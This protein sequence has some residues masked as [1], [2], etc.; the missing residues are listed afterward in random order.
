M[1]TAAVEVASKTA[2]KVVIHP[3][4]SPFAE[5]LRRSR[6]A[7]YDPAIRQTYRTPSANA[8]RGDWGLKRPISLRRRNAFI[9]I[10]GPFEAHAQFIEWNNA[11]GEVR[12]IRQLEEMDIKPRV[13]YDTPWHKSVGIAKYKLLLD[14]EFCPE[15]S[16]EQDREAEEDRKKKNMTLDLPGLGNRG[17]GM[18]SAKRGPPNMGPADSPGQVTENIDAMSTKEFARYLGK[19]RKLRPKFAEFLR[20]QEHLRGK[21]LYAIAQ[22][23]EGI[24]HRRF[25]QEHFK[26]EFSGGSRQVK[27]EQQPHPNAGLMYAQPTVL[28][29]HFHTKAQPGIVLNPIPQ[30]D[31]GRYNRAARATEATFVAS[32]GGL[33]A[34]L[35]QSE[36]GGKRALLDI[37]SETGLD[38]TR[39]DDSIA[40]MRPR[41]ITLVASPKVVGR[42]AQGLDGVRLEA[43]VTAQE[44]KFGEDNPYWPGSTEYNTCSRKSGKAAAHNSTMVPKPLV[45]P[46][47]SSQ[48]SKEKDRLP[49]KGLMNTLKNI[50]SGSVGPQG[51][52]RMDGSAKNL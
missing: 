28:D 36:A 47:W 40:N 7:T 2:S 38:L 21:S 25:L 22:N 4:P 37:D 30:Q 31:N 46:G 32:F 35:P 3:P 27:I 9:S 39:I 8:H 23:H 14:S 24:H 34:T 18:Y 43:Q 16:Y 17:P 52:G 41:Q 13:L 29:T 42:R 6:F 12:F 10:N 48:A 44:V 49:V 51:Q 1:A 11:Q 19:L 45:V 20:Q 33:A 15:E 50:M 5:L 26:Q